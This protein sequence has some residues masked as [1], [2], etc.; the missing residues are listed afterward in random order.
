MGEGVNAAVGAS[1]GVEVGVGA[2]VTVDSNVAA[3]MGVEV[4]QAETMIAKMIRSGSGFI[5]FIK[6]G[7]FVIK[8][9]VTLYFAELVL[10]MDL[11][12]P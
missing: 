6:D 3:G 2:A 7:G 12:I 5:L 10:F 4:S 11:E 9:A 1:V 8:A